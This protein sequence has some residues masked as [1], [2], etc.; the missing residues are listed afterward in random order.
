M[1]LV[2][3]ISYF[4]D[5]KVIFSSKNLEFSVARLIHFSSNKMKGIR[6]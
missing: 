2:C 5:M 1:E 4:E 3:C 6:R